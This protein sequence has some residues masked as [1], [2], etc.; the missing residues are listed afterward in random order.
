[1]TS[2]RAKAEAHGARPAISY[3]LLSGPDAPEGTLTWAELHAE[4]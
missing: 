4:K 3:Q 2:C 1:M